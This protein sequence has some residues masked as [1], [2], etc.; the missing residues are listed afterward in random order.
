M[1]SSTRSLDLKAPQS[2]NVESRAGGIDITSLSNITLHSEAGAV[3][4]TNSTM[5]LRPHL[6][7]QQSRAN[8]ET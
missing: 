4:T 6:Q 3:S 5:S 1:E 7:N 2:I 8:C